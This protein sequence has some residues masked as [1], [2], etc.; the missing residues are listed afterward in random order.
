MAP[1]NTFKKKKKK[2][3]TPTTNESNNLP[4]HTGSKGLVE[5]SRG[6]S[7]PALVEL[8]PQLVVGRLFIVQHLQRLKDENAKT[9]R[10]QK[11]H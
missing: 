10:G 2:S 1:I 3:P 11:H 5:V 7:A 8:G 6:S 9:L 4:W